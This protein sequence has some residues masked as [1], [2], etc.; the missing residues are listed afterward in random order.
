MLFCLLFVAA[1]EQ[2]SLQEATFG[3]FKDLF[4]HL[5]GNLKGITVNYLGNL[6][7]LVENLRRVRNPNKI[8]PKK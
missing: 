5:F 4:K 6:E 7:H 3:F 2:L 8:I 1:F